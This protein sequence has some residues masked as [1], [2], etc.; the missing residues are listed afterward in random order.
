MARPRLPITDEERKA[1]KLKAARQSVVKQRATDLAGYL[2]RKREQI[3]KQRAANPEHHLKLGRKSNKKRY[4]VNPE[5]IKQYM[6]ARRAADP[7]RAREINKKSNAKLLAL[8][9][10][11]FRERN[12]KRSHGISIGEYDTMV[13]A[14]N[15]R[16]AICGADRPGRE[17]KHWF[18]DHCHKTGNIRQLLC[19]HCN[20]GLGHFKDDTNLLQHAIDY[21]KRHSI[22]DHPA[23]SPGDHRDPEEPADC[24]PHCPDFQLVTGLRAKAAPLVLA[25]PRQ[26]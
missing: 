18:V 19:H 21:L 7:E 23:A 26:P 4:A 25:A 13:I 12:L 10:N 24:R 1:R 8:N 2:K 16:C 17:S 22:Q 3:A 20:V 9:P 11:L 6:R 5:P 15:D 14:Q